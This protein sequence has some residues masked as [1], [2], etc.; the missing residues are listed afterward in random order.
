MGIIEKI[1]GI[2]VGLFL[3]YI[4]WVWGNAVLDATGQIIQGNFV[5][6][7]FLLAVKLLGIIAIPLGIVG[8]FK[9]AFN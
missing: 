6:N 2:I 3:V 8:T 4:E 5:G 7:W 1:P 9:S